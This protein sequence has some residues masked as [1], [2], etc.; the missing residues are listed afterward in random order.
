M[1]SKKRKK[2]EDKIAALVRVCIFLFITDI[3]QDSKKWEWK[4]KKEEIFHVQI[5]FLWWER[6]ASN[7][8]LYKVWQ[9]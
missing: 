4:F 2:E 8:N 5:Y 9:N 3:N 6:G 1:G 7:I